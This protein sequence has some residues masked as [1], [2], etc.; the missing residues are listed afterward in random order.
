MRT[1]GKEGPG[2]RPVMYVRVSARPFGRRCESRGG[3]LNVRARTGTGG[4]GN[5]DE[6]WKRM[7]DTYETSHSSAEG[8]AHL[9]RVRGTNYFPILWPAKI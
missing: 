1:A 8:E 2:T 9:I 7:L 6:R 5:Q 4:K 3:G